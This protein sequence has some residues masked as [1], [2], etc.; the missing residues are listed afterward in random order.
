MST[1]TGLVKGTRDTLSMGRVLLWLFVF[2]SLY[3]WFAR[4][5]E[6]FPGSLESALGF[7]LAYNLG[8]KAVNNFSR[9][10]RG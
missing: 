1:F 9:R 5:P 8:G 2:V 3:F 7:A 10:R 4:P 6:A